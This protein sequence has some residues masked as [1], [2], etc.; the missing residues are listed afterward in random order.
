MMKLIYAILIGLVFISCSSTQ[1]HT[2]SS[3]VV[4]KDP[5]QI[6]MEKNLLRTGVTLSADGNSPVNWSMQMSYD[7]KIN[8][9]SDDG[10]ALN[11]ATNKLKQSFEN[12]KTFFRGK[13]E[14][15]YV[16]ITIIDG[17]CTVPT[18]RKVFSKVVT[19]T[20]NTKTYTGCGN[21]LADANLAGKWNLESIR[22]VAIKTAYYNFGGDIEVQGTRIK[23]GALFSTKM[24]CTKTGSFDQIISSNII[25]QLVDYYFKEGK[26]FLYL[27]DDSMLV[28]TRAAE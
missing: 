14:A 10:L 11:F 4:K 23:F 7:S 17:V 25:N 19:I 26:L 13:T 9:T 6:Q 3:S 2:R 8:F 21:F 18:M 28:F 12:E 24:A 15:G 20:V 1:K 22:T 16:S 27:P 5:V